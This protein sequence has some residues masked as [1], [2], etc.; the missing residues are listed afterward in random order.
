[1]QP[2][3]VPIQRVEPPA[4]VEL[5]LVG[6]ISAAPA[7]SIDLA[8]L[9][10]A[11]GRRSVSYVSRSESGAQPLSTQLSFQPRL[12]PSAMAVFIPVPPRGVTGGRRRQ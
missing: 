2:A 3:A 7:G 1:M 4:D 6:D 5:Q 12:N 8:T 11:V 9:C 10:S